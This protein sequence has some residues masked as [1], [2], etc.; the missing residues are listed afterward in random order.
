[1]QLKL[2]AWSPDPKGRQKFTLPCGP[3]LVSSYLAPHS[4]NPLSKVKYSLQNYQ[5]IT[6]SKTEFRSNVNVAPRQG[7]PGRFPG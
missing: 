3:G 6:S 5:T 7:I 2:T 4:G 1:M